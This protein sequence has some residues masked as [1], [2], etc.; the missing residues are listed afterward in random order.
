MLDPV[1]NKKENI[2]RCIIQIRRYYALPS[3]EEFAEDF[4]KQDAISAN[5]QRLCQL[6][7]DL[8]NLTFERRD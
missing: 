3:E 5:M 7:I 4:L 1:L 8:A 6:A 2:E